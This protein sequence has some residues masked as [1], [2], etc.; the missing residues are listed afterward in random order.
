MHRNINNDDGE[1][2]DGETR[3]RSLRCMCGEYYNFMVSM[4]VI[5]MPLGNVNALNVY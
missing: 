1:E 2:G 5:I 3:A 4:T